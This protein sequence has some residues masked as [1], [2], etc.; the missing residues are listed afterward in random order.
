MKKREGMEEVLYSLKEYRERKKDSF[1]E[2]KETSRKED[3]RIER[4]RETFCL[5]GKTDCV[6]VKG[7][8]WW[9]MKS[10]TKK[11]NDE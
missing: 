3:G 2:E 8:R 11:E 1:Y 10:S 6:E 5:S 9:L 7:M 4:R